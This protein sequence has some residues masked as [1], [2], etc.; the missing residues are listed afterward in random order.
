MNGRNMVSLWVHASQSRRRGLAISGA[1]KPQNKDAGRDLA[2]ASGSVFWSNRRPWD[3]CR[4]TFVSTYN[5]I[6]YGQHCCREA[7]RCTSGRFMVE[8]M[9]VPIT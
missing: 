3:Q 1:M 5:V 4:P 8:D 6:T 9:R 2:N 7:A